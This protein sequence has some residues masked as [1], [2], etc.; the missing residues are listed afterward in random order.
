MERSA[1]ILIQVGITAAVGLLGWSLRQTLRGVRDKLDQIAADVR[2]LSASVGV[3]ESQL[4]RG[5][6]ELRELKR[7]VDGLEDR[8]RH[9]V[10]GA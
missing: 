2:Q 9:S 4:A 1:E 8:E 10:G 3:H 6:V 7:R 5:D